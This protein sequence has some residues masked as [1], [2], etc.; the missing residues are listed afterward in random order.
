MTTVAVSMRPYGWQNSSYRDDEGRS[1]FEN[2]LR[3]W[4]LEIG[5]HERQEQTQQQDQQVQSRERVDNK[6][7]CV[8]CARLPSLSPY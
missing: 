8:C 4:I 1:Q 6:Y 2:R 5:P 7:E 3:Q